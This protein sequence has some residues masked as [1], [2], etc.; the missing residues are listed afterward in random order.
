MDT[1]QSTSSFTIDFPSS[2]EWFRTIRNMMMT[3]ATHVGFDERVA[4]QISMSVD[5][6]LSNIYRHGYM[7][8]SSGRITLSVQSLV[9]PKPRINIQIEDNACQVDEQTIQSRDIED[10]RPGGIGVYLIQTIMDEAVWSK[11]D[12]GGMR[13]TMCKTFSEPIRE[14]SSARTQTN[15]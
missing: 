1:A 7:G 2:P 13:L 14:T 3:T 15:D 4:G 9:T 8:D 12:A 5:E 11:R 6:A 10:V